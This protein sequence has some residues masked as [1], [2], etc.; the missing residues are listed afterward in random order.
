MFS[1]I[2]KFFMDILTEDDANSIFCPVRVI[3]VS[4]MGGLLAFTAW[5]I[6]HTHLFDPAVFGTGVATIAGAT[7]VGAGIKSKLGA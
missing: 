2:K 4:G 1:G 5:T 7:G 3:G 6:F